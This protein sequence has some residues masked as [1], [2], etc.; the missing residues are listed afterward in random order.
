MVFIC[1][2]LKLQKPLNVKGHNGSVTHHQQSCPAVWR[3]I[4]IH[5]QTLYKDNRCILSFYIIFIYINYIK[6]VY[7]CVCVYFFCRLKKEINNS[8][9]QEVV[10]TIKLVSSAMAIW[11]VQSGGVSCTGSACAWGECELSELFKS[12]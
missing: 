2:F 5:K 8:H 3:F 12:H 1:P 11:S 10:Q 6:Y 9:I 4:S 7:I